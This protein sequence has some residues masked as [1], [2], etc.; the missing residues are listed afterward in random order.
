MVASHAV[1]WDSIE[2]FPWAKFS[3]NELSR[4]QS[5][6]MR[7]RGFYDEA[8][9]LQNSCAEEREIRYASVWER[10]QVERSVLATLQYAGLAITN[11]ALANYARYFQFS[12]REYQSLIENLVGNHCSQNVS[13]V[14][15]KLLR[16]QM[17]DAFGKVTEPEFPSVKDNPFF[18]EQINHIDSER[19]RRTREFAWTLE[20]FQSLCSWGGDTEDLRLLVP[21]LRNPVSMAFVFRQMNGKKIVW[22]AKLKRLFL[23]ENAEAAPVLCE[24]IIC[25][26]SN[27]ITMGHKLPRA[28]NSF[29]LTNDLN[30]LY[31][32]KWRD[33]DYT[34]RHPVPEIA[35]KIK[36]FSSDQQ[37]LMLGQWLSL[38]TGMPDLLVQVEKF[39]DLKNAL[40]SNVDRVWERWVQETRDVL[41]NKLDYEESLRFELAPRQLYFNPY[42][43]DFRVEV[44]V[45]MGEWDRTNARLGK[46]SAR[47]SLRVS[48]QFLSWARGQW[49]E[50]GQIR[51]GDNPTAHQTMRLFKEMAKPQFERA[52][53]TFPLLPW[54]ESVREMILREVLE[55]ISIYRGNALKAGNPNAKTVQ[56]IP[57]QINL[58]LFALKYLQHKNRL[59][60]SLPP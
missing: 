10:Q 37:N 24:N 27:L 56:H 52:E 34:Y 2:T 7:L 13:V 14:S 4:H 36:T 18:P 41:G 15:L 45:N 23:R 16:R 19:N 47:F 57:V 60:S 5:S 53:K 29:N 9:N 43:K 3:A 49:R 39:S 58:G 55:Q 26:P 1:E 42:R 38:L 22:D 6:L 46:L 50:Y 28:L 44:D 21:L 48:H 30:Q 17:L 20:I 33:A 32:N 51:S 59:Q 25:R 40:R 31:C 54:G 8:Q 35:K 12:K 11:A